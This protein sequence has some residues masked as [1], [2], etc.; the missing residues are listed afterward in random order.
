MGPSPSPL[1]LFQ[2]RRKAVHA[3]HPHPLTPQ[4]TQNRR[5]DERGDRNRAETTG[6]H[7]NA[8]RSVST[9][10]YRPRSCSVPNEQPHV[11]VQCKAAEHSS[12]SKKMSGFL[13]SVKMKA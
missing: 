3:A 10:A 5:G 9:E 13:Q 2:L 6:T 8:Q 11:G 12:G 1:V 7:R 4:A